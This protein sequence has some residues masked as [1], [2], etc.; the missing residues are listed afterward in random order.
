MGHAGQDPSE[1]AVAPVECRGQAVVAVGEAGQL[2]VALDLDAGREVARLDPVDRRGDRTQRGG[3]VGREKV[4]K[5]D[6]DDYGDDGRQEEQAGDR[7][8]RVGQALRDDDE[9]AEDGEREQCRRDEGEG[10][11]G[12]E[13][14][15][16]REALGFG[17]DLQVRDR[18]GTRSG[19]GVVEGRLLDGR[20]IGHRSV[21][22]SGR[23]G[24]VVDRHV[25]AAATGLDATSR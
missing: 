1:L 15:S 14:E 8:L 20:L 10:Q 17:H 25:P 24:R 12:A 11:P 5:E 9:E 23:A 2:V 19:T 13:G 16:G 6:R 4:G 3:Q 21:R 22:P 7:R 18:M